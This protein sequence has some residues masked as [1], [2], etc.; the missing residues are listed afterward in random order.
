METI[1][2]AKPYE[3]ALL[4]QTSLRCSFVTYWTCM[5]VMLMDAQT[6]ITQ[7]MRVSCTN[8]SSEIRKMNAG[9]RF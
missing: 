9:M 1:N 2:L 5:E 8:P 7:E 6:A 4:L 3:D